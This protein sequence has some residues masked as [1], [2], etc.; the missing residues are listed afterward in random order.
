[1]CLVLLR[2]LS[3]SY[4]TLFLHLLYEGQDWTACQSLIATSRHGARLH[5]LSQIIIFFAMPIAHRCSKDTFQFAFCFF[6]ALY[7]VIIFSI[8]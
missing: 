8:N 5:A 2:W 1:M 4:C 6:I 7:I 3:Q